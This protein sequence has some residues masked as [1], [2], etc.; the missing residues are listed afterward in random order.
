MP[1]GRLLWHLLQQLTEALVEEPLGPVFATA[2]REKFC[3]WESYPAVQAMPEQNF[4][5]VVLSL[6]EKC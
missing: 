2:C 6:D 4:V 1:P 3:R 5:K